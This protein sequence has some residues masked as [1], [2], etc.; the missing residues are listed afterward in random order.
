MNRVKR[1][2]L[3]TC[4]TLAVAVPSFCSDFSGIDAMIS[5]HDAILVMSDKNQC[6]Y[7]KNADLPL[8][9]ASTLKV[10][11]ALAALHYL[12]EDYAFKTEFYL[13]KQNDL[14]I[15][16]FGDPLLVS[17][18]ISNCCDVLAKLIRSKTIAINDIRIDDSFFNDISVPGANDESIEPYDAVNGALCANFNTVF[19]KRDASGRLI[20]AES[21]T[22]L[23]PFVEKRIVSSGLKK[24]RILLTKNE[25]RVYAGY[26]FK[27]FLEQKGIAVS[28]KMVTNQAAA[29]T[30]TLIYTYNS[31]FSL[32]DTISQL[33]EYSNNFIANQLCLIMGA[34]QAG[35]PASLEKGV[36]ALNAYTESQCHL[37]HVS[38]V[39]GSGLSRQNRISA[40]DMDELLKRFEPYRSLMRENDR[41]Y[42]KTGTLKGISTRVGY[43]KGKNEHVYR[44][45]VFCNSP[46]KSSEKIT[47]KLLK[48]L[49]RQGAID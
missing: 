29:S 3:F 1:I 30:D 48:I 17:E 16:G 39:E 26:L 43:I 44:F 27:Y 37:T 32:R 24:G 47:K 31:I 6:L 14:T 13:D 5:D 28:G 46:N 21:Q 7:Q 10:L 19:F 34:H 18:N 33:L 23:L 15:K 35:P 22:P 4:I 20:S 25:S 9:P 36:A 38:L 40:R 12:G 2:L 8:V 45:V 11:T 49:I 41:T 42:Y